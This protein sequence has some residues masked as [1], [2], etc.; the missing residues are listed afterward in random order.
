MEDL[1]VGSMH[2]P[3]ATT[4]CQSVASLVQNL[5]HALCLQHAL[6][7]VTTFLQSAAS[8]VQSLLQSLSLQHCLKAAKFSLAQG[9][10]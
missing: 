3:K 7:E 4:F 9:L 6:P 8:I 5:S 2:S 1:T 10:S